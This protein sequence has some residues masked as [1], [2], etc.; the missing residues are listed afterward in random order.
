MENQIELAI[1]LAAV[2]MIAEVYSNDID[3]IKVAGIVSKIISSVKEQ[4]SAEM[5][6]D[7]LQKKYL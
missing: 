4:P 2:T 6:M 1:D 3:L 7:Y 5:L